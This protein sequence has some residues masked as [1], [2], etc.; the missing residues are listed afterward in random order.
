MT[1]VAH[2]TIAHRAY[3]LYEQRGREPGHDLDDWLM[4]EHD[5][6]EGDSTD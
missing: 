1:A 5:I 6:E 2:D 4:A 3:E